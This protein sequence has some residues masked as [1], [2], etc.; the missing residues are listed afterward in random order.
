MSNL[1]SATDDS[2]DELMKTIEDLRQR[3]ETVSR[4]IEALTE[5]EWLEIGMKNGWISY[6]FCIEHDAT[7]QTDSEETLCD[8]DVDWCAS[9]VR[10]GSP[11]EWE[12]DAKLMLSIL[13]QE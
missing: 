1:D 12:Q 7:P 5:N 9:V 3:T 2:L 8:R 6:P 13:E 4:R 10:L 11:D